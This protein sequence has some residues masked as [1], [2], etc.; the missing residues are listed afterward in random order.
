MARTMRLE[1]INMNEN[2]R[3][4]TEIDAGR[5]GKRRFPLIA[6][7]IFELSGVVS[8]KI[9]PAGKVPQTQLWI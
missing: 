4:T 1:E 2:E 6:E 5:E 7:L 8:G 3:I 9:F